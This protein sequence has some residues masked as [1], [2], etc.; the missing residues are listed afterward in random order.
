MMVSRIYG[1]SQLQRTCC[2]VVGRTTVASCFVFNQVAYC[3]CDVE[4]GDS[5]SLPFEF[6]GQDV[7]DVNATGPTNGF[8][9]S[10]FSLPESVREGR[11]R[12][13]TPAAP[14]RR[15]DPT[16]S[17][18]AAS[19]LRARRPARPSPASTSRSRKARS[20][21]PVRSR[22]PTPTRRPS[23][24]R[25]QARTPAKT[26]SSRTATPPPPTGEPGRPSRLAPRRESLDF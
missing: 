19:A 8:M 24:I 17:A 21:A 15:T 22:R 5:I 20:S 11:T 25:S 16:P 23:A 26:P 3:K 6:D 2:K 14:A 1:P 9:V 4:Q 7:C 13:S 12:L 18:T 10:T